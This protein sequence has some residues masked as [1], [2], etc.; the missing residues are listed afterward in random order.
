MRHT[1]FMGHGRLLGGA[2]SLLCALAVTAAPANAKPRYLEAAT[3]PGMTTFQ[4]RTNAIPIHP[5]QNLNDIG[6]TKTCPNATKESGPLSPTIFKNGSNAEGYVTRFKPSMVEILPDDRLVTPSVWDLHL[7]HVVWV[8]LANGGGPTFASGEEKTNPKFP[9]GYGLKVD[10]DANWGINQMIHDLGSTPGR[11]VYITWEIDWVPETTPAR[12]DIT[13][14]QIQWLDVAGRHI[15][16][17]FDAERGFD[18][19][20]DGKFVFP[21]EVPTDPSE[22]GYEERE[23]ISDTRRWRVPASGA[24]LVF[25]AG[26]LHPGGLSVDLR[27]ARD[28]PDPGTGDGDDPSEV[29][30]L[31]RSRA[32]YYEPAGAVSWDVSMEA[33]RRNWR[34]SLK[35][36]DVVSINTTYKVK[37]ASWYESMGILPLAWTKADDP[38]AKDPFTQAAGVRKMYEKGGILTHGRLREN[39]DRKAR[40]DLNLPDP[41]DLRAAGPV[42]EEGIGIRSF[43]FLDGGFSAVRGFP[44]GEMRPPVIDAGETVTFRNFDAQPGMPQTEQVW[45]SIT[46]CRAPCN[47][48]SGI[49]YPL[50]NGPIE[51][52]SG[53]LGYGQGASAGVTTQSDTFTT[54]PLTAGKKGS[55][56]TYTYFCRIHP[57]MRGSVR[58]KK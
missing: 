1:P 5:G 44:A 57:F 51:F 12:T 37:R 4:C 38:K 10:A 40:N 2:L 23:N 47:R 52:D 56:K 36:G 43:Y 8:D 7:H 25:G 26:H 29:R 16:P 27:V 42:P 3:Y 31:F 55:A 15:Y 35:P 17:V 30:K 50:A 21:D 49:G 13:D 22:P 54:P 14:T 19:D 20:G 6:L 18:R 28:G 9:Q 58:V 24:T 45:H 48:G 11:E 53:Q 33:T 39:I 41:R 32:H 34:I 46:S